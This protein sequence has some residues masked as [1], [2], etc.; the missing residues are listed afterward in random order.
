TS[1][2][3]RWR[4]DIC[5]AFSC[6]STPQRD[7]LNSATRRMPD[8]PVKRPFG[9]IALSLSGGGY[10]AAAF[11]L[12]TLD[13]LHRL[14]LLRDVTMLSTVSG[15]TFTGAYYALLNAKGR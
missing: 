7:V 5:S 4:G 10:R 3:V 12:G 14:Q 2:G 15:G 8:H 9:D 13:L 6:A 11:H 1:M